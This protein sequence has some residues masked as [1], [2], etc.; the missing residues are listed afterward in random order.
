MDPANVREALIE[1]TLD[2]LEGADA[3]LVKPAL[4]YLDVIAKLRE[5]THLPI[6]AY[7]VSGEYAMVMAAAEKGWCDADKVLWEH[8]TAIKR[9]GADMIFTYAAKN[10]IF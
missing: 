4:S 6:A 10:M 3:L 1:C 2:E 9:A 7:H 5:Q 8:L